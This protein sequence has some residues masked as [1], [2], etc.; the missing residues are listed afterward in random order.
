MVCLEAKTRW[1]SLWA[2]LE[3]FLE[4]K[5]AI[6]KAFVDIKEQKILANAEFETLT[7]TAT[8]FKPVKIGPEKL[9]SRKATL[10]TAEIVSFIIGELN[11]QNSEFDKNMKCCL[12]QRISERR[13]VSFVG[14]MQ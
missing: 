8:G 10:I 3:R 14:F 7:A 2:K 11:Q 12:I 6:S 13:N 1:N 4:I 9:C 5:S